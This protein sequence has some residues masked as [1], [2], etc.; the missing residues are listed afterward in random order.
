MQFACASRLGMRA[1]ASFTISAMYSKAKLRFS[2]FM[3]CTGLRQD[4]GGRV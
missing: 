3:I 4:H 2:V 1:D